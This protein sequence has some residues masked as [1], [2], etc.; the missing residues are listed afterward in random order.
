M[1]SFPSLSWSE[2]SKAFLDK[3]ILPSLKVDWGSTFS[4]FEQGSITVSYYDMRFDELFLYAT[5]IIPT[6]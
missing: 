1:D 6:K 4:I 5:M 2:F 3:F